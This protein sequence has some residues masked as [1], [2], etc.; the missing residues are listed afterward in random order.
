[1][2]IA[3]TKTSKKKTVYSAFT[4]NFAAPPPQNDASEMQKNVMFFSIFPVETHL[5][6]GGVQRGHTFRILL[7][8]L[9][10]HLVV[11]GRCWG[12]LRQKEVEMGKIDGKNR[13]FQKKNPF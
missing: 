5:V 9:C 6:D 8:H 3:T 4:P 10:T 13:G 11:G 12:W 2:L 1:M 7:V